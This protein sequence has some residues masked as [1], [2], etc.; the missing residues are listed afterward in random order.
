MKKG[1]V[2]E[3][4]ANGIKQLK[5]NGIDGYMYEIKIKGKAGSWRL[6]GNYDEKTGHII[7]DKLKDT[8]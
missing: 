1:F 8:H 7:F 4:G 5:G 6:L 3:S 2:G